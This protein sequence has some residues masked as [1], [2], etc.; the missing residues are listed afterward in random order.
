M[1]SVHKLSQAQLQRLIRER[2]QDPASVFL[3]KHCRLRMR[4]RHITWLLVLD[5]L[6]EGRLN[7]RPEPDARHG[8]LVCRMEHFV[9][10]RHLAAAVALDDLEPDLLVVTVIE[11]EK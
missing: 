2:S 8:S 5:V 4:Q 10:G 7:R 9:A 1:V 3:T 11:L 6:R